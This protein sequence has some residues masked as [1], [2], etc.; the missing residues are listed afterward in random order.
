M[1]PVPLSA[2]DIALNTKCLSLG[3]LLLVGRDN[4]NK[5]IIYQVMIWIMNNI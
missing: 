2:V 5:Y 3:S 1:Y 4:E